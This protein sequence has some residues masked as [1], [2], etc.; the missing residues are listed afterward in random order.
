[1]YCSNRPKEKGYSTEELFPEDL[2]PAGNKQKGIIC[3]T[4]IVY[5]FLCKLHLNGILNY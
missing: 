2:F 4:L 5:N 1:M 3:Y